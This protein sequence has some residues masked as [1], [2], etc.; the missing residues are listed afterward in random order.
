[1]TTEENSEDPS[2]T[3]QTDDS[4]PDSKPEEQLQAIL[5]AAKTARLS[6]ADEDRAVEL[7]K[8]TIAG[9]PK[10]LPA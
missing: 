4:S 10:A 3:E 6:P 7:L 2:Q 9:G 8:Q 1:M 5:E